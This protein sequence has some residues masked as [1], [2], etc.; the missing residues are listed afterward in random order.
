MNIGIVVIYPWRLHV[1][2]SRILEKILNE[3]GHNVCFLDCS[4][5]DNNCYSKLLG[6]SSSV[7][8]KLCKISKINRITRSNIDFIE[9]KPADVKAVEID[10]EVAKGARS[11]FTSIKRFEAF[12]EEF[13]LDDDFKGL[14]SLSKSAY[15][16]ARDWIDRRDLDSVF[17]FNG[18]M[19][20]LNSI[21]KACVDAGLKTY[22]FERTW[23]GDGFQI[24]RDEDCL[25]LKYIHSQSVVWKERQ[26]TQEQSNAAAELLYKRFSGTSD[27]EWRQYTNKLTSSEFVEH[28]KHELLVL[29]SS[30]CEVS[31]HPDWEMQWP[32]QIDGFEKIITKLQLDPDQVLVRGHPVWSERIGGIDGAHLNEDYRRWAMEKGYQYIDS[33]DETSTNQLIS[34]SKVVLVSVSSAAIEA[35]ILGKLVISIS[36][37]HFSEAGISINLYNDSELNGSDIN[38]IFKQGAYKNS[39]VFSINALRFVYLMAYRLPFLSRNIKMDSANS[40]SLIDGYSSDA[41]NIFMAGRMILDEAY[42]ASNRNFEIDVLKALREQNF[43]P[44]HISKI[45]KNSIVKHRSLIANIVLYL[46]SFFRKGDSL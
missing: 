35:A 4:G 36:P 2:Q 44:M 39:D 9:H 28:I 16:S 25:G 3:A 5:S 21:F 23:F 40:Y 38:L 24:L 26:L 11:S 32:S 1:E 37:N 22:S 12:R 30:M 34:Q 8:C 14:Y 42:E 46:R 29:P 19:D 43:K 41:I 7:A 6:R 31:N 45:D 17:V 13:F 15:T 18:R 10:P 20:M 27:N 33:S